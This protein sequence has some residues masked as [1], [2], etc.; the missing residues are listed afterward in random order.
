MSLGVRLLQPFRWAFASVLQ[1]LLV[2]AA[3]AYALVT[4][5][6]D[7]ALFVGWCLFLFFHVPAIIANRQIHKALSSMDIAALESWTRLLPWL[8]WGPPGHFWQDVY[9][10]YALFAQEKYPEALALLSKWDNE[11]DLPRPLSGVTAQYRLFGEALLWHWQEVVDGFE[12]LRF[13][14]TKAAPMLYLMA[15]RG[16]CELGLMHKASECLKQAHFDESIYPL[17]SLAVNLLPYFALNGQRIYVERIISVISQTNSHFPKSLKLLWL[18]RCQQREGLGAEAAVNLEKARDIAPNAL[19]AKR[20][21]QAMT[22]P[23]QK[24]EADGQVSEIWKLFKRAA[25]IQEILSPRRKSPIV[26]CLIIANI[27]VFV[28]SQSFLGTLGINIETPISPYNFGT[29]YQSVIEKGQYWR[30]ISYL[31]YHN[32]FVHIGSNLVGLYVFGRI[33]ENIFGSTRFLGIYF[34][35][36]VLSGL[37]H[38]FLS[39]HQLAVGASGAIQAVFAAC[40][41]GIY[42]L[43]DTLPASLRGRYLGFMTG[44]ALFQTVLDRFIP[45]I[46]GFAHLGGLISGLAL[47]FVTAGRNPD[48][49]DSLDIDGTQEFVDG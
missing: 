35:G 30:L 16:Y 9:M 6:S 33:A 47:G 28:S 25:F 23:C 24:V 32:D 20:I 22:A 14:R 2:L 37:A 43:R 40:A 21:E 41:A 13:G 4:A 7:L 10:S 8:N 36:G 49:L 29:S 1:P 27:L 42:K 38:D 12:K 31:F 15:C 26:N 39:P 18:G 5:D 34:V 44:I 3:V 19:V 46:A 11:K 17:D 45:A 48:A